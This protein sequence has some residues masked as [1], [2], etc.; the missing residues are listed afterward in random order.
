MANELD[1]MGGVEEILDINKRK[2]QYLDDL[3]LKKQNA[4]SDERAR[5]AAIIEAH[6]MK[7]AES[8]YDRRVCVAAV[9]RARDVIVNIAGDLPDA[10]FLA[11]A[12]KRIGALAENYHD[13]DG[14]YTSG[15]SVLVP[16]LDELWAKE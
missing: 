15:R 12:R 3:E 11:E 14:E 6:S 13:P 7:A 9:G 8:A 4:M 5:V 2:Q 10:E 16:I 1:Q